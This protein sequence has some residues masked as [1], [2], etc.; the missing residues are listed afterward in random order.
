MDFQWRVRRKKVL[1]L[2]WLV[3]PL[4]VSFI[5]W[6]IPMDWHGDCS[7]PVQREGRQV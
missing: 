2:E 3:R 1:V 5:M 4:N 7:V 6:T